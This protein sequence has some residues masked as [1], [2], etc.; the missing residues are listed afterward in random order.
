MNFLPSILS[1]SDFPKGG[2]VQATR[3]W[4]EPGPRTAVAESTTFSL[5]Q[6]PL[7]PE[8]LAAKDRYERIGAALRDSPSVQQIRTKLMSLKSPSL[9]EG[10]PMQ[11]VAV[12]APSGSGKTQL[13][14][15]LQSADFPC[16]HVTLQRRDMNGS[17]QPIYTTLDGSSNFI[18]AFLRDLRFYGGELRNGLGQ[19]QFFSSALLGCAAV[20]YFLQPADLRTSVQACTV[21]QL[22]QIVESME[23]RSRPVFF[24]DESLCSS[25]EMTLLIRYIRNLLR[26]VGLLAVVMGTDSGVAYMFRPSNASRLSDTVTTW[27]TLIT[28][29][30]AVTEESASVLGLGETLQR[31]RDNRHDGIAAFLESQLSTSIGWFV[32]LFCEE[33]LALPQE[34]LAGLSSASVLDRILES[35]AAKV[36]DAKKQMVSREGVRGQLAMQCNICH[37]GLSPSQP[38]S[39]S[40]RNLRGNS[41]H[42]VNC[43]F[44]HLQDSNFLDVCMDG[45][46]LAKMGC[47]TLWDPTGVFPD[48]ATHALLYLCLGGAFHDYLGKAIH[49]GAARGL[50]T[51]SAFDFICQ[52]ASLDAGNRVAPS[53]PGDKLEALTAAAVAVASRRHGVAGIALGHFLRCLVEELAVDGR[54]ASSG[55]ETSSLQVCW[56]QEPALGAFQHLQVPYLPPPNSRWPASLSALAGGCFGSLSRVKHTERVDFRVEAAAGAS[57]LTG[58]CNR[59]EHPVSL[60][61]LKGFVARAL[62]KEEAVHLIVVSKLQQTYFSS[63]QDFDKYCEENPE[64][65]QCSLMRI[66]A[67]TQ[68]G[69]SSLA[70]KLSALFPSMPTLPPSS[71]C[72]RLMLFIAVEDLVTGVDMPE[73]LATKKRRLTEEA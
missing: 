17:Q 26:S 16:V 27:C 66:V 4:L 67:E 12:V 51:F 46:E 34:A 62:S 53:R 22:S 50:N 2:D 60:D 43:H 41:H 58:E 61:A 37:G 47:R 10:L 32:E 23:V 42:F 15:C 30:P 28:E 3:A 6:W 8:A 59:F 56:E 57:G 68:P 14:Y 35:M 18:D 49:D 72:T 54:V 63:R 20:R 45:S 38:L 40:A 48:P 52:T 5:V 29:L 11:F 33:A 31:L 25:E 55:K 1:T 21:T 73:G 71:G 9:Y 7:A 64:V 13:P 70:I 19:I 69:S 24:L 39:G 44:A 36:Y 65:R